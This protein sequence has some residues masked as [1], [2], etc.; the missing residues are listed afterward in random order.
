MGRE[1]EVQG[2]PGHNG[3]GARVHTQSRL[4]DTGARRVQEAQRVLR[5]RIQQWWWGGG[6]VGGQ[7]G[8]H[9]ALESWEK[10]EEERLVGE[11]RCTVKFRKV[12][13]RLR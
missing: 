1:W 5:R 8:G 13:A 2:R 11:E 3:V 6:I 9:D 12:L 7:N 10:F 4:T